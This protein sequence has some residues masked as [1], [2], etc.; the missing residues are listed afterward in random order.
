[1][2]KAH[3]EHEEREYYEPVSVERRGLDLIG[4]WLTHGHFDHVA[5]HKVVTD[6]FPTA[7]VLMHELD[8]PKLRDPRSTVFVLPF[9]IP[10]R[11]PDELVTDGQVLATIG[12][13]ADMGS[14]MM[15]VLVGLGFKVA[16]AP[17]QLWV[18]DVYQGAPT[19]VTAFMAVASK[20]ASF[21]A[22]AYDPETES[23]PLILLAPDQ[24]T[25]ETMRRH[26][27]RVGIDAVKGYW[28]SW[29][30]RGD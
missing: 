4:L 30:R 1:M 14:T 2:V 23:K 17:F 7:R 22:W 18:P 9:T 11:E 6:R 27:M 28:R 19:S 5:D 25:A 20:A 21:G 15:L 3:E 26:L 8:A 29:E 13:F 16:A 24:E 10:P 12:V